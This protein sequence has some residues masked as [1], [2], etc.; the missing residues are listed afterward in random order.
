MMND[1]QI[2]KD[3]LVQPICDWNSLSA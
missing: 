2:C 3:K 1:E